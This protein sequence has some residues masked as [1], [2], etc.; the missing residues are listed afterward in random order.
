MNIRLDEGKIFTCPG[1]K[2]KNVISLFCILFGTAAL[3][4]EMPDCSRTFTL[5]Y[6][7]HGILYS[8]ATDS[9]IDKEVAVE[10]IKRSGC[11]F[12]ASMMPRSR[13]W[14]FIESGELDFSMSGITSEARGKFAG[15]AWYLYNRYYLLAR[16]DAGVNSLSEF[17]NNRDLE[18]GAIR[19]FRYSPNANHFVDKLTA[20]KRIIEVPDHKQLL[21]MIKLNRI[22]GMIIEPFNYSQVDRHELEKIT[23]IIDTGDAPVL[24]GLIMSKKS[25]PEAEQEKWRAIIDGMRRDGTLLRIMRKYFTPEM[26]KFMVTF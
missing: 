17:E 19:S 11:K 9:G 26:A 15:F 16:K 7:D 12:E 10:M 6:H 3:A 25:L 14:L 4:T 13:I 20:Q 2:L 5:A 18:I 22:Q 24:H 8:A 1:K 21:N 23:R